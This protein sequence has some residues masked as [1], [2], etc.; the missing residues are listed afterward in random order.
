M[1]GQSEVLGLLN[2]GGLIIRDFLR[3]CATFRVI[4]GSK[5]KR[6][7]LDLLEYLK[8]KELVELKSVESMHSVYK[9]K[10]PKE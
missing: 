4:N 7:P 6:F 5:V 3:D 1:Q 9:R 8:K 2:S 10:K